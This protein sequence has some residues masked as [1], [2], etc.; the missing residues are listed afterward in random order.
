MADTSMSKKN[1]T[2]IMKANGE[3][4]YRHQWCQ[5]NQRDQAQRN[6]EP[7]DYARLP[8]QCPPFRQLVTCA[9]RDAF[10]EQRRL[11]HLPESE[12]DHDVLG[13]VNGN[14]RG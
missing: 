9:V 10:F 2:A 12:P 11:P 1:R 14:I 7:V 8:G 5:D 13:S 3:C 6:V 4:N